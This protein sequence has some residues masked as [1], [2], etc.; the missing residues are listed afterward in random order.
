V[1]LNDLS[2]R[3]YADADRDACRALWAELTEHHRRIYD[4]DTIG[5]DDPGA[6]FDTYLATP[7]RAA[8]WVAVHDGD[9]VGLTGLLDLGD[10]GEVEPVV[11][12]ERLRGSGIG[13]LLIEHVIDEGRQ[14]G[15]PYM[16][17]QPVARNTSAIAAFHAVGFHAVGH[18]QLTMDVDRPNMRWKPGLN[19][20]GREMG[21]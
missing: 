21:W 8:S 4:D 5:G 16:T 9:V 12:A 11:V 14:R 17:I 3:A 7:A 19:I 1:S 2:I 20:H 13:R 15:F 10:H 6:H 18:I